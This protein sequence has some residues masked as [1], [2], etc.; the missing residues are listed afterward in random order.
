MKKA[1]V[2]ETILFCESYNKIE[3]NKVLKFYLE[4]AVRLIEGLNDKRSWSVR[5]IVNHLIR[6]HAVV[7]GYPAILY[8]F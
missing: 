4:G 1:I 6:E 7:Y 2:K 3:R 5:H 8:L